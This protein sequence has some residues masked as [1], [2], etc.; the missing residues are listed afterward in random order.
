MFQKINI[1][2]INFEILIYKMAEEKKIIKDSYQ[3]YKDY[4][5]NNSDIFKNEPLSD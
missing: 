5:W 3:K 1:Q 4:K 2:W